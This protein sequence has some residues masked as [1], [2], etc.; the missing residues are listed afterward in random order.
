MSSPA[1]EQPETALAPRAGPARPWHWGPQCYSRVGIGRAR[2]NRTGVG[3]PN[4]N[5]QSR[6]RDAVRGV[7]SLSVNDQRPDERR[8]ERR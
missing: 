8:T 4:A 1:Q 2:A 5:G 6:L 3:A 7:V